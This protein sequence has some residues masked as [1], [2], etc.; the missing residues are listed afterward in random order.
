MYSSEASYFVSDKRGSFFENCYCHVLHT[1]LESQVEER[2]R[3]EIRN[4]VVLAEA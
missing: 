1:L 3:S 2:E 4:C